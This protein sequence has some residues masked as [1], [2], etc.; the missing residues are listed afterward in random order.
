MS[1][2]KL[3]SRHIS[4]PTT[5]PA[6]WATIGM[7]SAAASSSSSQH[8][9]PQIRCA[10]RLVEVDAHG[11]AGAPGELLHPRPLAGRHVDVVGGELEHAVSGAAQALADP[12]QLL[13]VGVRAGDELTRLRPVDRGAR[14]GEAERS[15]PQPAL[16]DLGHRL[17]VGGVAGSLAAPRSPITYGPDRAVGH[18]GADVDHV[19]A[20]VERVEVALERLPVPRD[21]LGQRGAGDVLDALHQLDQPLVAIGRGRCE[22]DAAVAHHHRGHPVPRR[23]G[24]VRIPRGLAVVVGVDVDPARGDQQTR[25]IDDPVGLA[26]PRT[27]RPGR[28][29]TTSVITPSDTAMSA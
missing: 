24:E 26:D 2:L 22:A 3:P 1:G 4:R 13:G 18:L 25:R 17:D 9:T 8:L 15:G 21:A 20:C 19:L 29:S 10:V 14:R 27:A 16:D 11:A 28:Q 23:R 7:P 12:V 5:R 6:T